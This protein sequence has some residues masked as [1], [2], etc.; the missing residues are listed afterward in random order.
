MDLSSCNNRSYSREGCTS[1]DSNMK[2][3]DY[4]PKWEQSMLTGNSS[5]KSQTIASTSE[6]QRSPAAIHNGGRSHY[7]QIRK[8]LNGLRTW[9]NSG[10]LVTNMSRRID[11][12][13]NQLRPIFRF[14]QVKTRRTK[15]SLSE[16]QANGCLA[17][18]LTDNTEA[19]P[20]ITTISSIDVPE[21]K[22][23][24]TAS[25]DSCDARN[26]IGAVSPDFFGE[27]RMLLRFYRSLCWGPR[28]ALNRWLAIIDDLIQCRIQCCSRIQN[29]SSSE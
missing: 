9:A 25:P 27:S 19:D 12:F 17:P 18:K 28:D 11:S 2:K 5:H 26:T 23:P 3:W 22:W 8:H 15:N 6:S 21:Q 7:P 1:L 4:P 13:Q 20:C 24:E 16:S 14:F 10:P 29:L